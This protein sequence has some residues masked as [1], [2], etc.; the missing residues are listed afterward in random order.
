MFTREFEVILI[1]PLIQCDNRENNGVRTSVCESTIAAASDACH[2][3]V[4][5]TRASSGTPRPTQKAA[6]RR[7]GASSGRGKSE[8]QRGCNR[9]VDYASCPRRT[10][11]AGRAA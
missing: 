11:R 9:E 8:K 5:H 4:Q 1:I 2:V 7:E 10:R 3:R 6:S